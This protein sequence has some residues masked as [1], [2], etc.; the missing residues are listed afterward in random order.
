MIWFDLDNSPHIPIFKPV[1]NELE[2]RNE[3]YI[4]TARNFAQTKQLLELWNIKYIEAGKHGG[5]NKF[6]KVLNLLHRSLQL[7]K[8]IK[9]RNID[10]AVSHGSRSQLLSAKQS[11][12][13]SLLMLDYEYTETKIMNYF[14]TSILMPLYIPE[15]R[16]IEAGINVKKVIRYNGFKEELYLQNFTPEDSFRNKLGLNSDSVLVVIRPPSMV[17]NYHDSKSEKLLIAGINRFADNGNT[18]CLIVSRTEEDKRYI[19]SKINNSHKIRFLDKVVDGLQLVFAADYVISGGGTMNREAALLGTKTFSIFTG[20]RPYLDEYLQD[21]G[22]LKFIEK[23]SDFENI[24]IERQFK[25]IPEFSK[26]LTEE[27]TG[28]ILEKA[29]SKLHFPGVTDHPSFN[30]KTVL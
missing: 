8:I 23:L 17:A 18:I 3:T 10:L 24:K 14:S 19:L 7:S 11:G 20:R 13:R 16:L 30:S 22:K 27:V 12:I 26:N 15:K 21:A 5:K 29:E 6:K 2:K 9:D 4:I 28:I 1:F 25:P